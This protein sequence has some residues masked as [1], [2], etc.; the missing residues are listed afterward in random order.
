MIPVGFVLP[1]DEATLDILG[2]FLEEEPDIFEVAPETLWQQVEGRLHTNDY[3]ALFLSMGRRS[4]QRFLAHGVGYSVGGGGSAAEVYRRAQWRAAMARDQALFQF[5][6]YT[7]HL[8]ITAPAG[9]NT[10]LPL[11]LPMTAEAAECV[12]LRLDEMS[13]VVPVVGIENP[14]SHFVCGNPLDEPAFIRS[15]LQNPSRRL[16]LDLANVFAMASNLGFDAEEYLAALPLDQV[17]EIHMAGGTDS[18]PRWLPGGRS[19][20]L[21]GHDGPI[22][23]EVWRLLDVALPRCSHLRAI[24]LERMEGTIADSDVGLLREEMRRL[25][26]CVVKQAA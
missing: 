14:A 2:A 22:P 9:Q 7:D 5:L 18:D 1:P 12:R 6:W 19:L 11:P 25:R 23:P 4:G 15:V 10:A 24:V 16:L 3:H 13:T 20:R 26:S 8:G 17:I 21:D